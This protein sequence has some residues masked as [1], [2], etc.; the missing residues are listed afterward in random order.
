MSFVFGKALMLGVAYSASAGGIATLIGTPPNLIFA[1]FAQDNFNIEISFFQWM[2]IGLPISI[3][4]MVFIWLLL[5]KYALKPSKMVTTPLP[6]S[7]APNEEC[8]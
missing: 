6:A 7:L 8:G 4:L 2:K 3:V 1:G 5:T